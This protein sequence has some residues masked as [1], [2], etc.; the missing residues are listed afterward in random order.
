[1]VSL[2]KYTYTIYNIKSLTL[3]A[4]PL[5]ANKTKIALDW[6]NGTGSNFYVKTVRFGLNR[7]RVEISRSNRLRELWRVKS[8]CSGSLRLGEDGKRQLRPLD[9]ESNFVRGVRSAP[10]YIVAIAFLGICQ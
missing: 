6:G 3:A 10:I 5:E 4:N 1:M 2:H 8:Y 9:Y 7:S